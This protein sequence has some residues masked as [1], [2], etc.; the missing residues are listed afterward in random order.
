MQPGMPTLFKHGRVKWDCR[1]GQDHYTSDDNNGNKTQIVLVP[2][3]DLHHQR[4]VT[5][6]PEEVR[7][8]FQKKY[9]PGPNRHFS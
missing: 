9:S 7:S 6:N 3:C 8:T 2:P 1:T 5:Q 4:R